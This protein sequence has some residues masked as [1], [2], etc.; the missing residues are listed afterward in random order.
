MQAEGGP[1][2]A[3]PRVTRIQCEEG[4]R[5]ICPE[6]PNGFAKREIALGALEN[7]RVTEGVPVGW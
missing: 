4:G 3:L 7:E 1:D 2:R 5:E 6:Q